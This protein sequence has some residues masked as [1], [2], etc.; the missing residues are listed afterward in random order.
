MGRSKK[1]V[2]AGTTLFSTTKPVS[3]ATLE[4]L[5]GTLSTSTH[6]IFEQMKGCLGKTDEESVKK[7]AFY[8][9]RMAA[10]EAAK[11]EFDEV[12]G[13]AFAG[14]SGRGKGEKACPN[15]GTGSVECD[16]CGECNG[17]CSC[18]DAGS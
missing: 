18:S 10:I 4:T 2:P 15:C 11:A 13:P 6:Y 8:Q 5:K 14:F 9:A 16:G 12:F 3:L 1:T 17:C 7:V